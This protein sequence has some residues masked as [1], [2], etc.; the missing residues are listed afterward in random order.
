ML[1][2]KNKYLAYAIDF[3]SFVLERVNLDNIKEIIIFGSA[4][5]SEA[6]SDSDIDIF[7]NLFNNDNTLEKKVKEIKERFNDSIKSKNYWALKSTQNEISVIVGKLNEWKEL[8]NSII[9]NG[10]TVYKK[11][12]D[13]PEN[14]KQLTLFSWEN[15]RPESKRVLLS[16][17][18]FGYTKSSKFYEGLIQKYNGEKL[19][20]GIIAV[21]TETEKTFLKLFKDMKIAIKIQKVMSY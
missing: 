13:Q 21:P 14:A 11:F 10:I 20:K 1:K 18:L 3:V 4:A 7:I 12:Q 2:L 5:R 17:R 16:K 9:S 15:L 8:K 19:G 6:D